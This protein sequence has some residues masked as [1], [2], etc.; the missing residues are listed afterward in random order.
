MVL[1]TYLM[2]LKKKDPVL[3]KIHVC[4]TKFNNNVLSGEWIMKKTINKQ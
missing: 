1:E 3:I 2:N 4:I